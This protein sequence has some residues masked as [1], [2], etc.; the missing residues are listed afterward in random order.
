MKFV[1]IGVFVEGS[2]YTTFP[3]KQSCI[4]LRLKQFTLNEYAFV[5]LK[6]H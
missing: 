6:F 2:V 3:Q 1:L 5:K 4:V